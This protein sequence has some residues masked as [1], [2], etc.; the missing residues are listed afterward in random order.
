MKE[1][2]RGNSNETRTLYARRDST[3]EMGRRDDDGIR[4]RMA[5]GMD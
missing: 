4:L 5:T 2:R 3:R 1:T